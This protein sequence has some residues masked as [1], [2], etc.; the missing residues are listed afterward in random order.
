MERMVECISNILSNAE[1][2]L[3]GHE[4]DGKTK[5]NKKKTTSQRETAKTD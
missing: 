3:R 5:E 1:R 2:C 4:S